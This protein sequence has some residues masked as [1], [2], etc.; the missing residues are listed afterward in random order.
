MTIYIENVEDWTNLGEY[1]ER[2][3]NADELLESFV[4]GFHDEN[5]Q[6]QLQLLTAVVKLFLKRPSDTQQLVQRVLTL[7]TQES[8]NPDLRDRGYI[9]WRLLS[10]DPTAAKE[11]VLAEKPLIS[12]ETDLLE[13]SLLSKLV[14]HIGSLASVY[15]KPPSSFVDPAR[16]PIGVTKSSFAS[17][18]NGQGVISNGGDSQQPQQTV[19]LS[20]DSI[21]ADL[22]Q[23]DM[24][25]TPSASQPAPVDLLFGSVPEAQPTQP[26]ISTGAGDLFGGFGDTSYSPGYVP[27][28]TV[29]LLQ[30]TLD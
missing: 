20:Q 27:P 2:I 13:P 16:Q 15:H 1:A 4:E 21:I 3:D 23:L 29:R 10:A 8:D 7:A 30:Y 17:E 25:T 24:G 22:L 18:E 14:C 9:Y 12:E 6:V 11:V 28:K 26:D 19:I 5:T